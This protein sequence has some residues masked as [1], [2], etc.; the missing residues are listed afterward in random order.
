MPLRNAS[1]VSGHEPGCDQE[2]RAGDLVTAGRSHYEV[3]AIHV[4]KAW[5][6]DVETGADHM[7]LLSRCR[8]A[9][10]TQGLAPASK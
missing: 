8:L 4:G 10:A 2:I 3:L 7:A 1:D 6:R 5:L 9:E